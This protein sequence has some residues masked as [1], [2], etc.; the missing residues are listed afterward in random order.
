MQIRSYALLENNEII[1]VTELMEDYWTNVNLC[2]DAE[3]DILSSAYMIQ[4]I[5]RNT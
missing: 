4:V 3:R 2:N 1:Y 5:K